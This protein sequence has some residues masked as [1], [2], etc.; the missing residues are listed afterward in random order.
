ML[1]VNSRLAH[2]DLSYNNLTAKGAAV[3]ADGLAVNLNL[4]SLQVN[5][6]P[7][8]SD[9]ARS[10]MRAMRSEMAVK[11]SIGIEGCT[12]QGSVVFDPNNAS[13][14]YSLDLSVPYER[15]RLCGAAVPSA[16]VDGLETCPG[17]C[18]RIDSTGGRITGHSLRWSSLRAA[19]CETTGAR[20]WHAA[21][22]S[23]QETWHSCPT[24]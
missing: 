20:N 24:Q 23:P 14:K 6:N 21:D 5:F 16:M 17:G 11:R 15:V 2:L 8:G 3:V 12:L 19:E 18:R 4:E 13:G 10:L 7:I 1:T 9:G 22:G